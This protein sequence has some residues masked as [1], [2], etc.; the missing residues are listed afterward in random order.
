MISSPCQHTEAAASR[1]PIHG[2]R[3]LLCRVCWAVIDP[4]PRSAP[5]RLP[6]LQAIAVQNLTSSE[7]AILKPLPAKPI[8]KPA[9]PGVPPARRRS[10]SRFPYIK[11]LILMLICG[12]L[13]VLGGMYAL[14]FHHA[15]H[16]EFHE[17]S[18]PTR[19][20]IALFP[21]T[22][23]WSGGSAG[24]GSDAEVALKT[25]W[26][27]E[28]YQIRITKVAQ[29]WRFG[30][31]KEL[32]SRT[33]AQAIMNFDDPL[34]VRTRSDVFTGN[35]AVEYEKKVMKN[36]V[37]GRVI[38]MN[39]FAYEMTITGQD[40]SLDDWRVQVFFDSFKRGRWARW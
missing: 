35:V 30:R 39:D 25:A 14:W 27:T 6:I 40:L 21:G 38:I 34:Q 2:S 10:D 31:I 28:T 12:S 8:L 24:G 15:H 36:T 7:P 18:D 11:T 33:L 16:P 37:V 5:L 20:Y 19:Q 4:L 32:N 3:M 9:A 1:I 17:Y 26:S 23:L 13:I 22:P 29:S